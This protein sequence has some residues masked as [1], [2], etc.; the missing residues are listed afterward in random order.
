MNIKWKGQFDRYE[1]KT[2]SNKIWFKNIIQLL[3]T[4]NGKLN[5]DVAYINAIL[6]EELIGEFI[7]D[8]I[9]EFEASIVYNED[10]CKFELTNFKLL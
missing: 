8:K 2:D 5:I 9:I 10:N 1:F 4:E 7:V 3:P 6:N